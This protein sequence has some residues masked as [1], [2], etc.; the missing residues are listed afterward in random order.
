MD[1]GNR[2]RCL[3]SLLICM[4]IVGC[5]NNRGYQDTILE[6]S[7]KE[8]LFPDSMRL[9]GGG[10]IKAPDSEYTIV[11]YYD[12]VGCTGCKM[13]IP[14][15]ERFV[16]RIDSVAGH[17][18]VSLLI[19]AAT[20]DEKRLLSLERKDTVRYDVI[21]DESDSFNRL[22][23]LPKDLYLQ[24]F[25]LD[26]DRRVC[27]IGNPVMAPSLED[28]Y[29]MQIAG[30]D[31]TDFDDDYS[32]DAYSHDFG[33]IAPSVKVSHVFRLRN[34]SPDT[35]FVR[36][37]TTSCECTEAEVSTKTVLPGAD[38]NL[39]VTFMDSIAGDFFRRVS[40]MFENNEELMFEITGN[41]KDR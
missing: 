22:N 28:V 41:V 40:L 39:E 23:N 34:E 24:A 26:R 30:M 36:D 11:A 7:G 20:K 14:F 29:L 38:Y 17:D 5:A 18:R 10:F 19:I 31:T 9:V 27:V 25:L 37:V 6:W 2:F 4:L 33:D 3:I 8:I 21:I 32:N 35:L 1:S 12:S 16:K 13:N 15:W